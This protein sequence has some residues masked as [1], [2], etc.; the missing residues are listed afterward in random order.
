MTDKQWARGY[1]T[2][3]LEGYGIGVEDGWAKGFD[4]GL[5]E[6]AIEAQ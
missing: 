5:K 4:E 2:G 6:A 3:F 1:D